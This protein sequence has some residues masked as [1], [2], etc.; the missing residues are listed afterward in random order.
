MGG[1][2]MIWGDDLGWGI[3]FGWR[4]FL[5]RAGYQPVMRHKEKSSV[6]EGGLQDAKHF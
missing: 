4:L 2:T 6:R 3:D 1:G 5:N